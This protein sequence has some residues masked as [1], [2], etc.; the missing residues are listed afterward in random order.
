[1]IQ[2]FDGNRTVAEI[3]VAVQR[4]GISDQAP[5]YY[6]GQVGFVSAG[7]DDG[8]G[9]YL[10]TMSLSTCNVTLRKLDVQAQNI[11]ATTDG[12]YILGNLDGISYI[13]RFGDGGAAQ[14]AKF[15]AE[16]IT[17]LAGNKDHLFAA[18]NEITPS[19]TSI[20]ALSPSDLSEVDRTTLPMVGVG[21][22]AISMAV[23]AGKVIMP[24][25]IK[26]L[27]NVDA[28]DDGLLIVDENNM[29][30]H[31]ITLG[32]PSPFFVRAVGDTVYVA[33]TFLNQSFHS[34][35]FYRDISVVDMRD[36]STTLWTLPTG[37]WQFDVNPST[38]AVITN[39]GDGVFS[40]H[41]F[42]LPGLDPVDSIALRPP[43][44]VP[45]P[46]VATLFLPQSQ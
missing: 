43:A 41:T 23:V 30:A 34:F 8:D 18:S 32:A 4:V 10:V 39:S 5:A 6:D 17:G 22:T 13:T 9:S 25:T 11:A 28:E 35:A 40:L 24:M 21:E 16:F 42:A 46:L 3:P 26:N 27:N 45:D 33:H 20:I 36:E 15:P 7:N 37:V 12:F 1:M 44:S 19:T 38:L 29:S 14:V 31:T 2:M